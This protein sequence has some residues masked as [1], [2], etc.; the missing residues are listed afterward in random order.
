MYNSAN[1]PPNFFAYAGPNM[2]RHLSVVLI[3]DS[4]KDVS[5]AARILKR[6]DVH[7]LTVFTII[8]TA[9]L[10]LDEVVEGTR[11]CPDVVLL[12]LVLG[13]ESGFEVLRYYKAHPELK[14][15]QVVVWTVMG[16][17]QQELC[18][19]FGVQDIVSKS[20][21]ESALL[22]VLRKLTSDLAPTI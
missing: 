8:P 22:K 4:A 21:G 10:Y 1:Y 15:C 18:R 19:H 20:D 6:L 16:D 17:V 3:E 14:N 11:P 9:L 5:Q 13:S 7:K 2:E 12:D